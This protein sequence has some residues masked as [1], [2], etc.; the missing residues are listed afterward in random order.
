LDRIITVKIAKNGPMNQFFPPIRTPGPLSA[1]DAMFWFVI[2][3]TGP[4]P[5]S[6]GVGLKFSGWSCRGNFGK[7][8]SL[9]RL[10]CLAELLFSFWASPSIL[11]GMVEP[12]QK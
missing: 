8:I 11:S 1:T 4:T 12:S 7:F 10:S 5:F 2:I 6:H 9:L 3:L